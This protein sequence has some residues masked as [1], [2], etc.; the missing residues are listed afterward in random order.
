MTAFPRPPGS[1]LTRTSRGTSLAPAPSALTSFEADR[2]SVCILTLLLAVRN[3]I[4]HLLAD[5]S[6][7]T[8]NSKH[9]VFA[10]NLN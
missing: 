8:S 9:R 7:D 6:H 1:G 3:L 10:A 4:I 5:T 2:L